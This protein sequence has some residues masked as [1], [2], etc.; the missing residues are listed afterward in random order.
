MA[1]PVVK[2]IRIYMARNEASQLF[3]GLMHLDMQ[4]DININHSH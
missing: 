1:Y 3:S 2:H 4:R